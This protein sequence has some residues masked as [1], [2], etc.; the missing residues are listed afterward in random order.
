MLR[1]F[2]SFLLCLPLAAAVHAASPGATTAHRDGYQVDIHEFR[3]Q[4]AQLVVPAGAHV[5][6]TNR[7]EEPHIVVSAGNGFA[8]SPALDTGD[9]YTATFA[10]PGTYTYFCSIHPQ[11]VGTIVVK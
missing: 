9:R 4:P 3:F 5:T 2:F 7:D 11:M 10:K 8:S 1:T 6:W